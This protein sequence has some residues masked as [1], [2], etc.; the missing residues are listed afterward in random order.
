MNNNIIRART[1]TREIEAFKW[2]NNEPYLR[3]WIKDDNLIHFAGN[4]LEIW[5]S[6]IRDWVQC[7]MFFWIIRG[8]KGELYPISPEIFDRSYEVLPIG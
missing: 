6:D 7:P 3:D 2:E 4:M 5:N 8:I 1:I